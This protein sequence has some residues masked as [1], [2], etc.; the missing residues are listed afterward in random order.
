MVGHVERLDEYCMARRVLMAQVSEGRVRGRP[1]LGWM[2]DAKVAFGNTG[3]T[4]EAMRKSGEPWYIC[5]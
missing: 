1:R 3:M 5:D 4:V 2:D